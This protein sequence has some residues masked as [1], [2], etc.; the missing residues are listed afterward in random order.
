MT[1]E[2]AAGISNSMASEQK[3]DASKPSFAQIMLD[4]YSD[5]VRLA[6]E[7][8]FLN[9]AGRRELTREKL[10][11]WLTQDRFYALHGYPKFVASLIAALPLASPAH[12]TQAKDTLALLAYALTNIARETEFFD[13]LP[14]RFLVDLEADPS[15]EERDVRFKTNL[16]NLQ[17]KMMRPTT[18]AYVDLLIS[19]GAE[20]GRIGGGME[21]GIV[22]LW[23]MEKLY[24]T[25]WRYA[26]S[27]SPVP[28]SSRNPSDPRTSA[29]LDELIDNWTNE[30]FDEFVRECEREVDKLE[31]QEG[32][33]AWDRAE[34]IFKYVLY[35]E[36]RFW[37]D[38]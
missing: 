25:A 4:R 18:R 1:P 35:L 11:E 36:Q 31:L 3:K 10:S 2:Q 34:E 27:L 19:T 28:S 7:H 9:A 8:P 16:G 14:P 38:L 30:E 32:T 20:A 13:S 29:A 26:A 17:G 5:E 6:T 33:E 12:Q 21:E 37:P 15:P 24:N 22:L 23:T